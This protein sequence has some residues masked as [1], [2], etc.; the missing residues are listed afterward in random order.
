[1]KT[2]N[3][4]RFLL[5]DI[6]RED[7]EDDHHDEEQLAAGDAAAPGVEAGGER[8]DGARGLA[9]GEH[10]GL[11]PWARSLHALFDGHRGE[12]GQ[13]A[14]EL[15]QAGRVI[16]RVVGAAQAV[17]AEADA[18][19]PADGPV[20]ERVAAV[21][22]GEEADEH[23]KDADG[24]ERVPARRQIQQQR[25]ERHPSELHTGADRDRHA[26]PER[27]ARSLVRCGSPSAGRIRH[28]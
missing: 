1:M 6:R 4:P 7:G 25:A 15:A 26:Q 14:H 13:D 10:R 23:Q 20:G 11:C 9:G 3:I 2:P 12:K 22:D 8:A 27:G 5:R 28:T 17:A 21:V 16:L 18:D 19:E 24:R